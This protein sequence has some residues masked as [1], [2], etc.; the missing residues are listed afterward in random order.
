[1]TIFSPEDGYGASALADA[2]RGLEY[3]RACA[4]SPAKTPGLREARS[5]ALDGYIERARRALARQVVAAPETPAPEGT[6]APCSLPM[7]G[8]H[9]L[10]TNSGGSRLAACAGNDTSTEET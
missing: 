7:E 2:L 10:R 6:N 3:A 5:V 9:R 8:G 4:A 1:M